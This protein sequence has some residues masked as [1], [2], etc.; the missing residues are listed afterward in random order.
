MEDFTESFTP[1]GL[2]PTPI[3]RHDITAGIEVAVDLIKVDYIDLGHKHTI[4]A[5]ITVEVDLI[6][7]SEIPP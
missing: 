5:G 3:D 2:E 4:T 7:V 6:P 1:T